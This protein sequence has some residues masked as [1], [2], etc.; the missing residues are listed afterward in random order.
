LIDRHQARIAADPNFKALL[1]RTERAL[2]LGSEK[3]TSLHLETR[4]KEREINKQTLLDIE[5]TRRSDLGLP[6]I[7]SM[8][9]LEPNGKDFDPTEDASLMESARILLDEIQINPRLAGL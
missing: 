6:R 2:E 5:N 8:S 4:V 7:E 9:D 3:D 1:K